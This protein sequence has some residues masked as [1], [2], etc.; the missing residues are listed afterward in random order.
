MTFLTFTS[1]SLKHAQDKTVTAR[2]MKFIVHNCFRAPSL[3]GKQNKF[4][5]TGCQL[6]TS[7]FV[8][9]VLRHIDGKLCYHLNGPKIKRIYFW[10]WSW[11][12][13]LGNFLHSELLYVELI[14]PAFRIYLYFCQKY[15]PKSRKL[16]VVP[17][18]SWWNG[19]NWQFWSA[20]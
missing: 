3:L 8:A 20:K 2:N 11:E 9:I 17:Q 19:L 5:S 12:V 1:K 16:S 4:L 6:W 13:V 7:Q 15:T 18:F 10:Y 14:T